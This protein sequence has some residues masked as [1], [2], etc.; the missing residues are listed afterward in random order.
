MVCDC[1]YRLEPHDTQL[2][3]SR[4]CITSQSNYEV[5][6]RPSIQCTYHVTVQI[7]VYKAY[8]ASTTVCILCTVVTTASMSVLQLMLQ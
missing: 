6:V 5:K 8:A 4:A 2:K 1:L 3:A 7:K